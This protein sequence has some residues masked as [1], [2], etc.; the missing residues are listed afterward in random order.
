MAGRSGER[1]VPQPPAEQIAILFVA[2]RHP[3]AVSSGHRTIIA[4]E[5]D[6][7]AGIGTAQARLP[8]SIVDR[9]AAGLPTKCNVTVLIIPWRQSSQRVKPKDH[10]RFT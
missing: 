10:I 9:G 8:G 4:E 1:L 2:A 3:I 7:A 6:E 5:A